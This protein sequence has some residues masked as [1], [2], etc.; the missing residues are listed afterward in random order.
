MTNKELCLTYLR[1]Y[2]EKKLDEIAEM[3]DDEIV[4]RDWNI[5][6]HGKQNALLETRKNFDAA[7]S[8]VIETLFLYENQNSI[9][10]EL[11]ITLNGSDELYVI[12]VVTFNF[13]GKIK[14][15]RAYKGR[16]DEEPRKTNNPVSTI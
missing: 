15:I 12:D 9:A 8:I 6:V 7:K 5:V 3:F 1:R 2:A 4:L 14:S 13:S 10:A 11:K 16:G